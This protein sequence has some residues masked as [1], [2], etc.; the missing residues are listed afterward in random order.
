MMR[1]PPPHHSR[2][3]ITRRIALAAIP[4]LLVLCTGIA[5]AWISTT[6]HSSGVVAATL[7]APS[8]FVLTRTLTNNKKTCAQVDL[9]WSPAPAPATGDQLIQYR[10]G[11][12]AWNT[13]PSVSASIATYTH[14][15]S[16]QDRPPNGTEVEY[17]IRSSRSGTQWLSEWLS[18]SVICGSGVGDVTDLHAQAGAACNAGID[19][20]WSAAASASSYEVRYR[21]NGGGWVT[22]VGNPTTTSDTITGVGGALIEFQVRGLDGGSTGE[23]SNT[24]TVTDTGFSITSIEFVNGGSSGRFDDGDRIVVTFNRAADTSTPNGTGA[25]S[26]Y[27][28]TNGNPT[29]LYI[30]SSS[31]NVA[32]ATIGQIEFNRYPIDAKGVLFTGT[33]AWSG[34]GTVWTWTKNDGSSRAASTPAAITSFTPGTAAGRVVCQGGGDLAV[35]TP[36]ISGAF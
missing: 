30:G 27:G 32:A 20:T 25:T 21:I 1:Q 23:W 9:D 22:A 31:A 6:S 7:P 13:L 26:L 28:K 8:N 14:V 19:L 10:Y 36:V 4:A 3:R 33:A 15:M 16:K 34:G 18:R 11:T 12:G 35:A 29:G 17:Q 5:F 24:A 2:R